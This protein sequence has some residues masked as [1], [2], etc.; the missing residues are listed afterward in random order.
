MV[1][2]DLIFVSTSLLLL[3]DYHIYRIN[4]T[5]FSGRERDCLWEC[6]VQMEKVFIN[7]V[8]RK[9]DVQSRYSTSHSVLPCCWYFVSSHIFPYSIITFR[10]QSSKRTERNFG[11]QNSLWQEEEAF[12][13]K[14]N[15]FF[16]PLKQESSSSSN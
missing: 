7:L 8:W 10:W 15:C 11:V 3:L 9:V 16:V 14:A 6:M 5:F 13:R 2:Y 4:N 12:S 1:V